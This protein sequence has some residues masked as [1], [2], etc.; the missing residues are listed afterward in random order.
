M[1]LL[2]ESDH[3]LICSDS[4]DLLI[5]FGGNETMPHDVQ[6]FVNGLVVQIAI[7][8][9]GDIWT[10]VSN[11]LI[12]YP[13]AVQHNSLIAIYR[14]GPQL[15]AREVGAHRLERPLGFHFTKCGR[16]SC[17]SKDR[18][19]HVVGELNNSR[20]RIRCKACSWRSGWMLLEQLE[21]NGHFIPLHKTRAPL[22]FYHH[23]PS[24]AE[25]SALFFK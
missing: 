8:G 3:I 17:L 6:P 24:P 7:H 22:I 25:L 13:T 15:L 19:G 20:V 21:K 16:R 9:M 5:G 2:E 4:L 1:E 23:F 10:A 14:S 11:A 12:S 18:P